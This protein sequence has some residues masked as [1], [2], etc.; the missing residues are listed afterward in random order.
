MLFSSANRHQALFYNT[1][2]FSRS[3]VSAR[4]QKVWI[5]PTTKDD[6]ARAEI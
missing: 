3:F 4:S 5:G 2:A 1:I 6:F